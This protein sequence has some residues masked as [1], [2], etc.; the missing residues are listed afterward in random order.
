MTRSWALDAYARF[1]DAKSM[2]P[3]FLHYLFG[4]YLAQFDVIM[5]KLIF[6]LQACSQCILIASMRRV[7]SP[8][9]LQDV[10]LTR[11]TTIRRDPIFHEIPHQ[12][13][14]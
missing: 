4:D 5:R 3:S 2:Q 12:E 8:I 13:R 9:D 14:P 7:N 11:E 6:E 1:A 10:V